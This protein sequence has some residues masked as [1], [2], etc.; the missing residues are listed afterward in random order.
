MAIQFLEQESKKALANGWASAPRSDGEGT[1]IGKTAL[2][3]AIQGRQPHAVSL[4]MWI[5]RERRVERGGKI[6]QA[7]IHGK[8]N[9]WPPKA[10]NR[11]AG[12]FS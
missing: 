11:F 7:A 10:E 1:M 3:D 6:T 4:G 12:T 9:Q 2:S 8:I 5:W